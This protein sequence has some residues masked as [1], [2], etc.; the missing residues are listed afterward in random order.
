MRAAQ[1]QHIGTGSDQRQRIRR[2]QAAGFRAVEIT[3]LDL[4]D[5]ARA[6]LGDHPHRS[7]VAVDQPMQLV[8]GQRRTRGQHADHTGPGGGNGRLHRRLH[9][10]ERD[11]VVRAQ[12][13]H[14]RDGCRVAGH[15]DQLRAGAEQALGDGFRPRD[16][17]VGRLLAVR[18]MPG[19]GY[20]DRRQVRPLR[21]D[22]AQ[23][24]QPAE[25]GI[26]DADRGRFS[27]ERQQPRSGDSRAAGPR[28]AGRGAASA[29]Q[30]RR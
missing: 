30:A 23:H 5:Q 1:H 10:D 16:D 15:H 19:I 2:K 9:A 14:G 18:A 29:G 17:L 12:V 20:V 24:R 21:D 7:A 22:L 3:T 28:S 27:H 4:L 25:A 13:F 8:A 26:E 6:R 11:R